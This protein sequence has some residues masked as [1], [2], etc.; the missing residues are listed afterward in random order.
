MAALGT[1]ADASSFAHGALAVAWDAAHRINQGVA[2]P[3]SAAPGFLDSSQRSNGSF[4][5][6]EAKGAGDK[7]H[8]GGGQ[9]DGGVAAAMQ[10]HSSAELSFCLLEN[11]AVE[12]ECSVEP[13]ARKQALIQLLLQSHMQPVVQVR[14]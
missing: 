8:G 4:F 9:D 6:G 5:G 12:V 11:L 14:V 13:W 7:S 1:S 10:L 3:S 2:G